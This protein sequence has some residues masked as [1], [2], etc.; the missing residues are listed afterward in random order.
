[1]WWVHPSAPTLLSQAALL[2]KPGLQLLILPLWPQSLTQTR[3]DLRVVERL[4]LLPFIRRT[5]WPVNTEGP[6]PMRRR[7]VNA[8]KANADKAEVLVKRE[9]FTALSTPVVR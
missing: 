7:V 4:T 8:D 1:M 2:E 5:C 3:G 6:T 9:A